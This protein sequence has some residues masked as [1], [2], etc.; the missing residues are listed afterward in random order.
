MPG[1][2]IILPGTVPP[3]TVSPK[4]VSER[5][6]LSFGI[7]AR[8]GEKYS[9]YAADNV[10]TGRLKNGKSGIHNHSTLFRR[11]L[12]L[13]SQEEPIIRQ[14]ASQE[15]RVELHQD[16]VKLQNLVLHFAAFGY[17]QPRAVQAHD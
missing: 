4:T 10:Q 5:L 9:C 13:L 16:F 8:R 1:C 15:F 11:P 7:F 2:V 17:R 6:D 3:K 14:L 12:L